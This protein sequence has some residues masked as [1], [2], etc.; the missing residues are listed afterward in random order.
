VSRFTRQAYLRDR[1]LID[2][3]SARAAIQQAAAPLVGLL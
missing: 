3:V 1:S 2:S